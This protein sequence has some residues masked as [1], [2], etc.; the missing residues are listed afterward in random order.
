M[1]KHVMIGS[2]F[3]RSGEDVE[4]FVMPTEE[5]DSLY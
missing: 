2:D 1:T 4:Y 3:V 5:N